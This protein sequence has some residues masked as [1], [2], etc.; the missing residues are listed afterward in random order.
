MRDGAAKYSAEVGVGEKHQ[1]ED[2]LLPAKE[3]T[4]DGGR[5]RR[6]A[7]NNGQKQMEKVTEKTTGEERTGRHSAGGAG[8]ARE[9]CIKVT[10]AYCS[11]MGR[12]D[13]GGGQTIDLCF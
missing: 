9:R 2:R 7:N 4:T 12:A 11:D 8:A 10:R 6:P 13:E 1:R 3:P 5:D